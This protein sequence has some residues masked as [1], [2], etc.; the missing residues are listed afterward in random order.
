MTF[1]IHELIQS[2]LKAGAEA[3][4]E[5]RQV[6][7]ID[8]V[9]DRRKAGVPPTGKLPSGRKFA[10]HGIG[11]RFNLHRIVVDMDFGRNGETNGFDAWRLHLHA[12]SLNHSD[13]PTRETIQESLD[14]LEASNEI[15][16]EPGS[17]LYFY[18]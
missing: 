6:Y 8:C 2:Y 11:C 12:E 17:T 16:R 14:A 10:F 5:L 9:F 1:D 7:K 4:E 13:C 3:V 15:V 18:R